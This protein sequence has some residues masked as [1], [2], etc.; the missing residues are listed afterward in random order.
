MLNEENPRT[1]YRPTLPFHI[2]VQHLGSGERGAG[3]ADG[4]LLTGDGCCCCWC[5]GR[6]GGGGY[7]CGGGGRG[8]GGIVP[9][10]G[11]GIG[12]GFLPYNCCSG[13]LKKWYGI[14]I[15]IG[16]YGTSCGL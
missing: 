5:C 4:A 9:S 7:C 10:R 3:G 6:G 1:K 2:M 15:G 8:G 11:D 14:G 16:G 12:Y 13:P